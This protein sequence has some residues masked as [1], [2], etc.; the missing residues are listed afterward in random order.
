MEELKLL[1]YGL[2]ILRKDEPIKLI[3]KGKYHFLI[4]LDFNIVDTKPHH[5]MDWKETV[6]QDVEM[7]GEG[8]L[9]LFIPRDAQEYEFEEPQPFLVC[10]DG[11][12]HYIWLK[13]FINWTGSNFY[14]TQNDIE[15]IEYKIFV[16]KGNI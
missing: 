6:I 10:S 16:Q 2:L 12:T 15:K 9:T 11:L 13:V 1:N 8:N 5:D 4:C 14:L 7:R 3:C